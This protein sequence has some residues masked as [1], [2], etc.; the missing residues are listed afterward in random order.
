MY[1]YARHS[2]V[3]RGAKSGLLTPPGAELTVVLERWKTAIHRELKFEKK[4]QKH[5]YEFD[6]FRFSYCTKGKLTLGHSVCGGVSRLQGPGHPSLAP[7]QT[8]SGKVA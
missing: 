3:P 6:P 5:T 1:V 8:R 4:G 2:N 7:Q